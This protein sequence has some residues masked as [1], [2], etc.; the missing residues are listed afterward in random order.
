MPHM[1]IDS[2]FLHSIV[3][4]SDGYLAWHYLSLLN[5]LLNQLAII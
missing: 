2:V 3:E 1:Y 5:A 4:Q